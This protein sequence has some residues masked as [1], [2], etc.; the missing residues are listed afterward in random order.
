MLGS[1]YLD[2]HFVVQDL[3]TT[4]A[5]RTSRVPDS[6]ASR[7]TFQPHDFF[8]PQPISDADFY[9]MRMIIHDWADSDALKILGHIA[10]AM[11]PTARLLI[12]D[13]VLPAPGEGPILYEAM[14]RVRD[15]TMLEAFNSRERDIEDW[16]QLI[17]AVEPKLEL[18][19]RELP[20][21]S[22]MEILQLQRQ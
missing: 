5:S 21:G 17:E 15:L 6:L 13:T 19:G 8:T 9:L 2:L 14:L 11:K 1:A 3:P 12:M 10:N 20:H 18:V 22:A 4:L 16:K 7:V